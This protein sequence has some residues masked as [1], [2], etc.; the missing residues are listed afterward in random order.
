VLKFPRY[1][2]QICFRLALLLVVEPFYYS[3]LAPALSLIKEIEV[4][5]GVSSLP[6]IIIFSKISFIILCFSKEKHKKKKKASTSY[7]FVDSAANCLYEIVQMSL[8]FSSFNLDIFISSRWQTSETMWTLIWYY[9]V[10]YICHIF[11]NNVFNN[12]RYCLDY[13]IMLLCF[14]LHYSTERSIDISILGTLVRIIVCVT[15][16]L[17]VELSLTYYLSELIQ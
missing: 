2:C 13:V 9:P 10:Q 8:Q 5:R 11:I 16:R 7:Q 12:L 1:S 3:P 6:I 14:N 15:H 4:H 17:V